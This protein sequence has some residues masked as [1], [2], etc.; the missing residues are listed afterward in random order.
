MYGMDANLYAE[1]EVLLGGARIAGGVP[2][3]FIRD[4]RRCFV[5]GAYRLEYV[6]VIYT[7]GTYRRLLKRV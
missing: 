5:R 2:A 6:R 3:S 7:R 1:F 4:F